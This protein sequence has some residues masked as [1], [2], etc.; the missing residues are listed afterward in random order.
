MWRPDPAVSGPVRAGKR[1]ID[2]LNRL[3]AEA[4]TERYRR[5]GLSGV[6]VPQLNPAIWQYA[7]ADAGDGAMLWRDA[8]GDLVAFNMVHR[9]GTEGWMGPLAVRTDRQGAGL[10]R[11][12]VLAG[13]SWLQAQGVSTIGL[14][15]M[16]R[17]V[18]NIGFYSRL[19]FRPGHLTVTLQRAAVAG[20]TPPPRLTD[21]RGA[22]QAEVIAECR[23]L[24]HRIGGGIDFTREIELTLHLGLGD[25]S[26]LRDPDGG[27]R[28]FAL[29]HTAA[30]AQGRPRD[31]LRVLKLAA[32]DVETVVDLVAGLEREAVTQQLHHVA[33]RCQTVQQACY[34]RLVEEGFGVQWTDLRLTLAGRE[35]RPADGILF[36]NWEI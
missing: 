16:P 5:D 11:R 4:F 25:V 32:P 14:E 8:K 3:F 17:T 2:A 18:D 22:A 35:E 9:S 19:G 33:L 13:V 12:I 7:I 1:D 27:L 15:T 26:L 20:G 34:G 30:L 29:W 36:S 23:D 6:R 10:G 31:D 28:A 21:L 24:S